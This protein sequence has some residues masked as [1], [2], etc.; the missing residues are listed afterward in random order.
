MFYL[1]VQFC[2]LEFLCCP[3]IEPLKYTDSDIL[4]YFNMFKNIKINVF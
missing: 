2:L 3:S 4:K 1:G